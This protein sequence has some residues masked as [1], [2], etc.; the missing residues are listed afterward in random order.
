M[1]TCLLTSVSFKAYV[2]KNPAVWLM[3]LLAVHWVAV[4]LNRVPGAGERRYAQVWLTTIFAPVQSA[5]AWGVSGISDTWDR[6]FQLRDAR[7]ENE[8]LRL[9]LAQRET[10]LLQAQEEIR[11][12]ERVRALVNWPPPLSAPQVI[13]RVI[14]RDANQWFNSV[15]IDR[16]TLSGISKDQPVVT[17]EGLVGRVIEAGPISARVLLLT[18]E[19]HG[20]GAIIGQLTGS[21][22]LG[23]IKGRNN[24]LCEMKFV[25]GT[26]EIQPGE[27]VITSGQ[28]G[29]YPPGL[30]I[31]KI[32]K[33]ETGSPTTPSVI[34]IEPAAPLAKLDLVG[35]LLIAPEQLREA[36]EQL[37]KQ[38]REK[39]NRPA[40][41]RRR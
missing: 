32:T 20:A 27:T 33:T 39:Q 26:E 18:D 35:V 17:P 7:L 24:L 11:L 8:L 4:S 22:M 31:G 29:I 21:R 2:K 36:T 30:V 23:V 9:R 19:R 40:T 14:S 41:R 38:E 16:G 34:E 13:A 28:D 6:Y 25:A 12:A 10:E 15:V 1:A 5:V 3:A 37:L